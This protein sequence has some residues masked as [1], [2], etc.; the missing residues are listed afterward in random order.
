MTEM[1]QNT[2]A[3]KEDDANTKQKKNSLLDEVGLVDGHEL[4]HES[5]EV[6]D[7]L[8]PHVQAV[9]VERRPLEHL[10]PQARVEVLRQLSRQRLIFPTN[11][12]QRTSRGGTGSKQPARTAW[13]S[14]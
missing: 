1:L 6:Q 10:R 8:A 3:S 14:E 2:P 9:L 13:F 4:G 7:L 12:R 5:L 11:K